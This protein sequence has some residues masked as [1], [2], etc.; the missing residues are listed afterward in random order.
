MTLRLP[1][2]FARRLQVWLPLAA[3]A[4]PSGCGTLHQFATQ[5]SK[6]LETSPM[7]PHEAVYELLAIGQGKACRS[8]EELKRLAAWAGRPSTDEVAAGSG[9]LYEEA[10]YLAIESV[11]TADNL[12]FPRTRAEINDD[13]IC[14]YVTGRAYRLTSLRSTPP[15][16]QSEPPHPPAAPTLPP[17][18]PPTTPAPH[19]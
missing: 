14:V 13:D 7:Y 1:H 10:K 15:L 6:P 5:P 16:G 17:P 3:L 8:K 4:F 12:L 2:S 9:Y 11:P 19:P 18:I